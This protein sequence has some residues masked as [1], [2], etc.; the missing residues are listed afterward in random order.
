MCAE[1]G[2][3]ECDGKGGVGWEVE[4]CITFSPVSKSKSIIKL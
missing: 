2:L 3:V 1:V 4:L